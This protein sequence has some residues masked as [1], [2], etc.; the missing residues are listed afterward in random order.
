MGHE[1]RRGPEIRSR[2]KNLLIRLGL[3]LAQLGGL[4]EPHYDPDLHALAQA[5]VASWEKSIPG[6][7]VG[8]ARRRKVLMNLALTYPT[9]SRAELAFAV[10]RAVWAFRA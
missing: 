5:L 10:E 4:A 8:D 9:R 3:Y 2:V 7:M 1:T 6:T